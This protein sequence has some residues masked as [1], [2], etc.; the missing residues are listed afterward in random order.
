MKSQT[1]TG[2]DFSKS[3]SIIALFMM[4]GLI[5]LTGSVFGI[6]SVIRNISFSVLNHQVHGAIWGAIM[7]LLGIRYLFSVQK[8]K[9]MVYQSKS[10]FSWSNFKPDH[11]R[12]PRTRKEN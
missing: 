9:S 3:A 12:Q 1:N 5:I 7:V 8:L 4:A 10:G 11:V 2:I 6:F